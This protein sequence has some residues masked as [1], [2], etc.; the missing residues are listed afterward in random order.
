MKKITSLFVILILS[1]SFS[2]AAFSQW[3]ETGKPYSII[4]SVFVKDNLIFVGTPMGIYRSLNM[5]NTWNSINLGVINLYVSHFA[6]RE[7]LIFAGTKDKGLFRSNDNGNTWQASNRGL[8]SQ[9]INALLINDTDI[10]AAAGES[11]Y[12]SIDD[13]DSFQ[14]LQGISNVR[15]LVIKDNVLYAATKD[16]IYMTEDKGENWFKISYSVNAKSL[17]VSGENLFA[18]TESTGIYVSKDNGRNWLPTNSGLPEYSTVNSIAVI[19]SS[20]FAGTDGAGVFFSINYGVKWMPVNNGLTSLRVLSVFASRNYLF[21]GSFGGLF[22]S[23]DNGN[24]WTNISAG[25]SNNQTINCF[26]ANGDIL[27]AGTNQGRIFTS[28]NNG[29]VWLSYNN[30]NLVQETQGK[31]SSSVGNIYALTT[32]VNSLFAATD[33]GV[34]RSF[35]NGNTFKSIS[36]GLIPATTYSIAVLRSILYAGTGNGVYIS[37]NDGISWIRTGY[38]ALSMGKVNS[39]ALKGNNIYAGISGNI[40]SVINKGSEINN[41]SFNRPYEFPALA[42]N[43]DYLFT[44]TNGGGFFRANLDGNGWDDYNDGL[45][46]MNLTSLVVS[47]EIIIVGSWGGGIFYSTDEGDEW[48]SI[49]DGLEDLN[50]KSLLINKGFVFAGTESGKIYKRDLNQFVEK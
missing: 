15:A 6:V 4:Y 28:L 11:L 18:G 14:P 1:V 42:Y 35:D 7:N 48:Y 30:S 38:P 22:F 41:T 43:E 13:G 23:I 10:Y 49:N 25:I 32:N 44:V 50:I 17:A 2:S 20:I 40:Y 33:N 24:K 47:G 36:T 46:N 29:D 34:Y 37:N 16:G 21:A 19:G 39:L 45:K 5:G 26:A 12:L 3:K 27:F 8:Q 9:E 31:I